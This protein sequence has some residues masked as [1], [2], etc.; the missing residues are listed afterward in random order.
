MDAVGSAVRSAGGDVS[1]TGTGGGT[2]ASGSN[3][4]ILLQNS[5]QIVSGGS[6]SLTVTGNG[7]RG[8]GHANYGI[9]SLTLGRAIGSGDGHVS[10]TGTGGGAGASGSNHGILLQ[11]GSQIAAGG[12]GNVTVAGNGGLTTGSGNYG[13]RMFSAG[14]AITSDGGT[15][16]V[17]GTGGGSGTSSLNYGVWASSSAAITSGGSGNVDV[18]GSGGVGTSS[19]GVALSTAAQI[20]A[21]GV[22]TTTVI[23]IGGA[24]DTSNGIILSGS[25]S[26]ITS[27]GGEVQVAA[28]GRATSEAIWLLSGG[29]IASGANAPISITADSLAFTGAPLGTINSGTGTT[30]IRTRTAGTRVDLGGADVLSGGTLTLGL[31]VQE[32]DQIF[33]SQLILGDALSGDVTVSA[34]LIRPQQTNLELRSGQNIKLNGNAVNTAGGTLKLMTG[35]GAIVPSVAGADITVSELKFGS[36][37]DLN[38]EINGPVAGTQHSIVRVTGAV[39]LTGARLALTGSYVP[40]RTDQFVLIRN[41]AADAVTGTFDGLPQGAVVMFNGRAMTVNYQGGDGN[42]VTLEPAAVTGFDV[43]RGVTQRSFIRILDVDMSSAGVAQMMTGPG[44]FRLIRYEMDGSGPGVPVALGGAST[45][46]PNLNRVTIDFGIN[47]LTGNRN[48]SAGDGYYVLEIDLNGNGVFEDSRK[49]YR[50]FGDTNGD[51]QVHGTDIS[52]ISARINSTPFNPS[53]NDGIVSDWDI[54]GDGWVNSTDRALVQ[55][56][57]GRKIKWD[58]WL[59]D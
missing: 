18:I 28:T 39:N 21:N 31:T 10:V 23:G 22:G 27:S 52:N 58:L 47:G 37:S 51:R 45:A 4:G 29:S 11:S 2:G 50:L 54:N 56:H 20:R 8:T 43:Q 53:I 34:N 40:A 33:A 17:T 24:A 6:G 5:G 46:G 9:Y 3:Y 16:S 1:V 35:N 57:V 26:L 30:T 59:D 25:G 42:D 41:D 15:V 19:Y 48:S 44:R 14:T 36:V 38:F 7:G 13:V 55:R 49:F 32:L 12:L